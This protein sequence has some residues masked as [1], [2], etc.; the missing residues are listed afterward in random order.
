MSVVKYCEV[1]I[2]SVAVGTF[3]EKLTDTPCQDFS[4]WFLAY[5]QLAMVK[6]D[7]K[8]VFFS[9]TWLPFFFYLCHLP[10]TSQL[11]FVFKTESCPLCSEFLTDLCYAQ[12]L[13]MLMLL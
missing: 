9:R 1:A 7:V 13:R 10:A 4:L 5:L 2:V 6:T 12:K 3:S 8:N 11:G